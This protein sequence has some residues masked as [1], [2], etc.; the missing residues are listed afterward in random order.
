MNYAMS[1]LNVGPYRVTNIVLHLACALLIFGTIRRTLD[2]P[3]L[4]AWLS[5]LGGWWVSP[6][7]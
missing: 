6:S 3:G 5:V 7:R 1:G 2:L 4:P